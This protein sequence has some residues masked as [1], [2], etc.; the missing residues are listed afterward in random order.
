ML[1]PVLWRNPY[2]THLYVWTPVPP[3]LQDVV[4]EFKVKMVAYMDKHCV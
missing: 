1:G 2:L 3:C 4:D